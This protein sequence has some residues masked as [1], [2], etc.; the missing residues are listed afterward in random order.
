MQPRTLLVKLLFFT[1]FCLA[2]YPISPA[3]AAYDPCYS[4]E[5]SV[6]YAQRDVQNAQNNV[7]RSQSD[8]F[9]AQNQVEQRTAMYQAQIAQREANLDATIASNAAWTTSC[10]AQGFF[11]RFRFRSCAWVA[12]ASVNRRARAQAAVNSARSRLAI[13]QNY[14]AGYI[15]RMAGRVVFAEA[16]LNQAQT[17]LAAA[18]AQYQQCLAS[19]Q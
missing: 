10:I 16:K 13:Y 1:T 15:Q 11:F 8:L 14:S 3:G 9:R 7:A 18:E 12:A 17:K 19:Q 4:A 5:S 6:R 2:I